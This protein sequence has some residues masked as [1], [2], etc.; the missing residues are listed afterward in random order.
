MADDTVL[1]PTRA[2]HGSA[3]R[4]TAPVPPVQKIRAAEVVEEFISAAEDGRVYNRSGR[5]YKPSALRDLRGCLRHQFAR[6]LGQM[7]LQ[8]VRRQ[9][10]Q[11][12]V[13]RLA[14]DELSLSRIRS[15]VSAIRAL[16]GYAIEQGYVEFSPA[17]GLVLPRAP[18]GRG[19]AETATEAETVTETA[20]R[21]TDGPGASRTEGGRRS[22]ARGAGADG[23]TRRQSSWRERNGMDFQPLAVLPERLL[24]FVLRAVAVGFA[25]MVLA[26]ILASL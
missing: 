1:T 7:A 9:H 17:D 16:Y 22:E 12:L 14:A 8:D 4:I 18:A 10:I 19:D 11:A 15:V 25:L 20:W 5:L 24:S 26:A 13:D 6:D 23:E 2:P 21:W 3:T